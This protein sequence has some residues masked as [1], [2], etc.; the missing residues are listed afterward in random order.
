MKNAWPSG[1]W[2]NS[3]STPDS[4]S[5]RAARVSTESGSAIMSCS[6]KWPSRGAVSPEKLGKSSFDTP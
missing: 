5:M 4:D 6:P 1:Y 2:W 3:G